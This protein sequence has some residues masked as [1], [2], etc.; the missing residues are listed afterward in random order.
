MS[1]LFSSL[2]K[3]AIVEVGTGR[4]GLKSAYGKAL[5]LGVCAVSQNTPFDGMLE[6]KNGGRCCWFVAG[7]FCDGKV[8][9]TF[10][11][12]N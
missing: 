7:T 10:A 5:E 3:H 2:L 12:K 4:S 1:L 11:K 9:G 8:K 6:G